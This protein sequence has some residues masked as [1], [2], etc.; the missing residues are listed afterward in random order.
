VRG[1]IAN[2][3]GDSA[4]ASDQPESGNWAQVQVNEEGPFGRT[5]PEEGNIVASYKV[6]VATILLATSAANAQTPR[7]AHDPGIRSDASV[8]A[9]DPFPSLPAPLQQ[10]FSAGQAD[11]VQLDA[12]ADGLGPRM[13]L[14]SCAGCHSNPATGGTSPKVNPQVQ[15]YKSLPTTNSLPSFIAAN[16]PVREARFKS[17]GGVHDLF[18]IAGM[19]G[20]ETCKIAQPSFD[21][22]LTSNPDKSGPEALSDIERF[23]GF[24]RLL[25][26]PR[27]SASVP[28]GI[29][30]S[31]VERRFS[32]RPDVRSV[33]RRH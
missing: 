18:T 25:A 33:T 17:D 7:Q 22:E 20:A 3:A 21:A 16:G 12:V 5:H 4:S 11:F 15:F 27:P 10:M 30:P 31:P 23:A 8:G 9:G 13:N 2:I 14:N 26:P 32:A 28:G 19:T 29:V 24:M 6:F 1:G